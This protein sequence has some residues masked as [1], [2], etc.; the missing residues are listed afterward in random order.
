[1]LKV[2]LTGGVACGKS[3][4]G[5]MF[6]ARGAELVKAD[7]IAHRLM[8]PGQKVY[9]DVV[10]HFGREILNPDGTINRPK[11]AQAAF[12]GGH[13]EELNRLVHP[14]VIAEQERWMDEQVARD[15]AAVVIVE[16]ALI[17]EAGVEKRFDKMIMVTC[18]PGQKAERFAARQGLSAEDARAEVERRQRA[19]RSDEEKIRAADYVIDNSETREQTERSVEK[20]WNELKQLAHR[21]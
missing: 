9:D 17:L 7:E 20:V 14:A 13:V 15:P 18:G 1:M 5:D 8:Q 11:L 10:R 2:G 3:T 16:A 12:G 19:Q 21:R 6:V 4:V